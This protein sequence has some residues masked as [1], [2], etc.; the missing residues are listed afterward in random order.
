[1]LLIKRGAFNAFVIAIEEYK[2]A[3]KCI[4][5]R[6]CTN[7]SHAHINHVYCWSWPTL[8]LPAFPQTCIGG[9]PQAHQDIA[10]PSYTGKGTP[11]HMQPTKPGLR[12]L[13]LIWHGHWLLRELQVPRN[14][15]MQG[16]HRECL[17][18]FRPTACPSLRS[19]RIYTCCS[20][21]RAGRMLASARPNT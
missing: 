2:L 4:I 13:T 16:N 19:R 7:Q 8:T 18:H 15:Q 10:L 12:N 14:R 20:V 11:A 21:L 3:I 5:I 17:Q 1:M 9:D 6:R